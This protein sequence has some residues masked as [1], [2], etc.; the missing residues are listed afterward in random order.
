MLPFRGL[1]VCL[2]V[3]LS[4]CLSRSCIVLKRQKISTQFLLHT[5]NDSLDRVK[6]W[7]FGLAYGFKPLPPQFCPEVTHPLLIRGSDTFG[8]KLRR[9]S[10]HCSYSVSQKNPPCGFLTFFPKR[11][12]I[13][14]QFF[15][16]LLYDPLYTRLQIFVHL[17]PNCDEVMPY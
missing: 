4:I 13:F 16:H 7:K 17:F 12:R 9:M 5:T 10:N 2:S 14:N 1:S 11:L 8:D 6:L 15:T 3:S